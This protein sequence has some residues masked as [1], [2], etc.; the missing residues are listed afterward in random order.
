MLFEPFYL[1]GWLIMSHLILLYLEIQYVYVNCGVA[2][3][4]IAIS[5]LFLPPVSNPHIGGPQ[6][7][8]FSKLKI[9]GHCW[10]KKDPFLFDV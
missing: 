9:D 7:L 6:S 3:L 4:G 1:S 5:C 10:H 8:N 2:L